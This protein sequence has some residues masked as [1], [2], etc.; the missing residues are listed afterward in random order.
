MGTMELS[1]KSTLLFAFRGDVQEWR[2][3]FATDHYL[4]LT[5]TLELSAMEFGQLL[6]WGGPGR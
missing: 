6:V 5:L 3:D 1:P 2:N 4:G